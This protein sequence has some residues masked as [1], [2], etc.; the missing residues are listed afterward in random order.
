MANLLCIT[1]TLIFLLSDGCLAAVDQNQ[2]PN[3]M[4]QT[5]NMLSGIRKMYSVAVSVTNEQSY[6]L[7]ATYQTI[8]QR[9][10]NGVFKDDKLIVAIKGE[11]QC[12]AEWLALGHVENSNWVGGHLLVIFSYASPCFTTCTN[13]RNSF[14]IIAKI[15]TIRGTNKWSNYAFVFDRVF[16]P[17]GADYDDEMRRRT[18]EGLKRLGTSIGGLANVF[19]CYNPRDNS[20]FK[21]VSCSSGGQV[22]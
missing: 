12:H 20:G 2:L 5:K 11:G 21:C 6:N 19:R 8:M 7:P 13:N 4:L 18:G 15:N 1:V 14:N 3:L 22:T 17:R 10:N 9:F 16:V